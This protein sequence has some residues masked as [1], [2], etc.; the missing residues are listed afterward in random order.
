[1]KVFIIKFKYLHTAEKYVVEAEKCTQISPN[2]LHIKFY[3]NRDRDNFI[4]KVFLRGYME[5]SNLTTYDN[6][7]IIEAEGIKLLEEKDV[8]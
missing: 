8:R 7:L 1:M 3:N 4:I 5:N 6:A 2:K